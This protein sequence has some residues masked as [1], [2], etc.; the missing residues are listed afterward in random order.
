MKKTF[1]LFTI[2]L[3]V[4]LYR[5]DSQEIVDSKI[6]DQKVEMLLNAVGGK[7][8]WAAAGGFHMVEVAHYASL[9]H[10]L[11]REFWIDFNQPRIKI[12]SKSI[13]RRQTTTLNVNSGWTMS[14]SEISV[15]DSARVAGWRSFWP[16]IPTRI[17]NLLARQH[18]SLSFKAF[19]NRF[20]FFID[21]NFAV[22]IS[23]NDQGIPVAYGRSVNKLNDAHFLGEM[24]EYGSV[25]LWRT[26]Y[27]PGDQWN[28]EMVDYELLEDLSNIDYDAPD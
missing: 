22:W 28:V 15:W 2:I 10:P 20:D 24:L 19:Q 18:P 25:R 12:Q 6:R 8:V 17:F 14:D 21:G 16:G 13:E 5:A 1:I 26:A 23:V 9:K 27:E 7:E 3:S 4:T 11:V